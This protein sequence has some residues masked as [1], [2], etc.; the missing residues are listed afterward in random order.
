M[1]FEILESEKSNC[2]VHNLAKIQKYKY[3]LI[4]HLK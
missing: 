2:A 4:N 3:N 1:I